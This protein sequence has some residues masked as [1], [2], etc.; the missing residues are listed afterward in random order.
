M[1]DK[2]LFIFSRYHSDPNNIHYKCGTGVAQLEI[3]GVLENLGYQ[4]YFGGQEDSSY[5]EDYIKESKAIVYIAPAL[6]KFIKYQ[7]KGKL[8]LF[9]NNTHVLVRNKRMRDS[10]AKWGLP[11]ESLGP[12]K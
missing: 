10:A 8:I 6:P 11:V 12:E 4:V 9:A 5:P 3:M 7:P 1:K 2:I